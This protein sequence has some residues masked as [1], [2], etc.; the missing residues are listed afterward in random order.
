MLFM[1]HLR[2]VWFAKLLIQSFWIDWVFLEQGVF[3]VVRGENLGPTNGTRSEKVWEPL[4]YNVN[5]IKQPFA[6]TQEK[7]VNRPWAFTTNQL[8]A[9]PHENNCTTFYSLS[10]EARLMAPIGEEAIATTLEL[11]ATVNGKPQNCERDPQE[12]WASDLL[13]QPSVLFSV[14]WNQIS[15]TKFSSLWQHVRWKDNVPIASGG[16]QPV[17]TGSIE[18][19]RGILWDQRTG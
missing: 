7:T 18:P 4:L 2:Q 5:T 9:F 1:S 16:I 15:S 14:W 3:K 13:A 6:F 17:R 19:S 12:H 11:T 10:R 8:S